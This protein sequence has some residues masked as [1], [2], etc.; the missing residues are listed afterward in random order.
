MLAYLEAL[1]AALLSHDTPTVQGLLA[2]PLARGLPRA[3]RDEALAMCRAGP[4]TLRAP[5][6]TLRFYYQTLQ[7]SE[8]EPS[9]QAPTASTERDDEPHEQIELV[10]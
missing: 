8:S 1:C 2:Q 9:R 3:V 10:L 6:Q 7:L 5:M 4:T